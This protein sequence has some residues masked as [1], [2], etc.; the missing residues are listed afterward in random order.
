MYDLET[1]LTLKYLRNYDDKTYST[2][3][4]GDPTFS[5]E[6]EKTN[7]NYLNGLFFASY[8][9][10]SGFTLTVKGPIH[11]QYLEKEFDMLLIITFANYP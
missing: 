10:T 11:E 8:I 9:T 6:D 2:A 5:V 7:A 1:Y 3:K 4:C